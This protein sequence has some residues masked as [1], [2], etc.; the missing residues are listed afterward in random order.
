[1]TCECGIVAFLGLS[2]PLMTGVP[3]TVQFERVN[4]D[5]DRPAY[6]ESASGIVAI[7]A[8]GS[9]MNMARAEARS[10]WGTPLNLRLVQSIYTLKPHVAYLIDHQERSIVTFPCTC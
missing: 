8:D 1:M 4:W 2:L 6:I 7:S 10:I 9:R 3:R 5:S